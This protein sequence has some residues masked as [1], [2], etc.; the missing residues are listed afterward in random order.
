MHNFPY[1]PSHNTVNDTQ[2]PVPL[3]RG[4]KRKRLAKACDACHKSKRRCDGTAP[5]SNCYFA[6]KQ[7]TYTD[8][9]GRPVPAPH[10]FDPTR[11]SLLGPPPID[12]RSLPFAHPP[13]QLPPSDHARFTQNHRLL[14]PPS[15][16]S[17]ASSSDPTDDD[18][19]NPRKRFRNDRGIA[20]SPDDLVI[21]GPVT[22]SLDRPRAVELDPG[23]MRELTNLFFAHCHPARAIIHKPTFS[24]NLSHNRVPK[25]L[26]HAVCALA[27]PLSK[28][29]RIRTNPT[30]FAGRP[31]AQEALSLMFDGA[32]R[33]K[34]EPNLATA[35]A[36]CLLQMHD[37]VT[38][39]KNACWTSR[40]HDLALRIVEALG[41]HSPEHPTLTPVPSPEFISASLEREAIR[42]IF[43][44]IHLLDLKA[45]IYFKK[46]TTFT[47]VEL[48]L[49]LPVDETSFELGVHSTL[50]VRII[51]IYAQVE[52]ILDDFNVPYQDPESL[53]NTNKRLYETEQI[54]ENWARTLPDH[55]RFS[56]QSLQVQKSMFETSSNTG[57]WCWCLLHVYHASCALALSC[58]RQRNTRDAIVEPLWAL[59]MIDSILRMIGDRAKNS[60]LLG[61][62]LWSLIKYCK[63][64][65][66]QCRTG[67]PHPS[68]P[69]RHPYSAPG[70]SSSSMQQQQQQQSRP[71]HRLS[72][73][74]HPGNGSTGLSNLSLNHSTRLPPIQQHGEG[75]NNG[76]G[77]HGHGHR[78]SPN[79]SP[80]TSHS[81]L[82]GRYVD[83]EKNGGGGG[84]SHNHS[85]GNGHSQAITRLPPPHTL[86]EPMSGSTSSTAAASSAA[87][88]ASGSSSIK[89]EQ[90]GNRDGLRGHE[91][92][93]SQSHSG[94]NPPSSS[95]S[96]SGSGDREHGLNG[97]GMQH[98][99]RSPVLDTLSSSSTSGPG[100]GSLSSRNHGVNGTLGSLGSGIQVGSGENSQPQSLPSLKA[101]GLLDWNNGSRMGGGGGDSLRD[102]DRDAHRERQPHVGPNPPPRRS[103]PRR[104][105]PPS[106]LSTLSSTSSSSL[107]PLYHSG[108]ERTGMGVGMGTAVGAGAATGAPVVP[109]LGMPVGMKWLANESR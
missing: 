84:K 15:Q 4:A 58:G 40:Y 8:A 75:S 76:N 91:A 81:Y 88:G 21:D 46:P 98:S 61:A 9:S 16:P 67:D 28:Q 87:S 83:D 10:R 44:Y 55:L 42:R 26:L 103:S 30:R 109:P 108:D 80:G 97:V 27:A 41:V 65:D 73:A 18:R 34:C 68:P 92:S 31:F 72:D 20:I 62:A 25:Y 99:K 66:P 29:P 90:D 102:R 53:A 96:S 104:S 105:P 39:E 1:N 60:L 33:L 51:T 17:A 70:Q 77:N 78:T 43:W 69:Q 5:C 36:L 86:S 94:P 100:S 23:L 22:T 89:S 71:T 59:N 95:S 12:S 101:S 85:D 2:Q 45:S 7:C 54:M 35:Q 38:K 48:R 107:P 13:L 106:S 3:M 14:P 52:S 79:T 63:R 47:Q 11:A 74:R 50:P 93:S 37:I 82:H 6:S 24:S 56:E 64:D 57:A 32:G 49:R 19:R